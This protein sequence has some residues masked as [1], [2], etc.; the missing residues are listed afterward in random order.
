MPVPVYLGA[1]YIDIGHPL[2]HDSL[3]KQF[4]LFSG[5]K[6]MRLSLYIQRPG[7]E[8]AF[9]VRHTLE[10][11]DRD[12]LFAGNLLHETMRNLARSLRGTAKRQR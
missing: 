8:A 11:F 10:Q 3:E 2:I 7:M 6:E 4:R 1:S 5:C 12:T 9:H